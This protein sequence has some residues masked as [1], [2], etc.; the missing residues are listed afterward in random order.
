MDNHHAM[1]LGI[2]MTAIQTISDGSLKYSATT[3][4][5]LFFFAVGLLGYIFQSV[6]LHEG[7]TKTSLGITNAY[8]N[9]FTTL[10]HAVLSW[11]MGETFTLRQISALVLITAGI[12]LL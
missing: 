2:W 11:G 8:W 10:T 9:G 5:N 3:G 7:L 6:T 12:W 1:R 4:G